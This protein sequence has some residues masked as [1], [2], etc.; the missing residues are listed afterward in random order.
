[1]TVKVVV[2][3]R[4]LRPTAWIAALI[5]AVTMVSGC[6]RAGGQAH[7]FSGFDT[8]APPPSY[9]IPAGIMAGP[10]E[11]MWYVLRD[12]A[13][14]AVGEIDNSGQTVVHDLP[15]SVAQIYDATVGPDG[16]VWFTMMVGGTLGR[17]MDTYPNL[18]GGS[19][20]VGRMDS[21]GQVRVF[22]MPRSTQV[23]AVIAN[24]AGALWI[25][26]TAAG[27]VT[28]LLWRLRT[29]GSF[30]TYTPPGQIGTLF[31]D[32]ERR[33]W[34]AA[35]LTG[36]NDV[37]ESG[38]GWIDTDGQAHAVALP[39]EQ[40]GWTRAG[41]IGPDG[42]PWFSIGQKLVRLRPDGT[43]EAIQSM[44]CA[45]MT[46][47]GSDLWCAS[48]TT[49]DQITSTGSVTTHA[50]PV[51]SGFV[52]LGSS[53]TAGTDGVAAAADGSIWYTD[54]TNSVIWHYR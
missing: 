35:E 50:L 37:A 6:A 36:P 53:M 54:A 25:T 2:T 28:Q 20:A 3:R 1:M 48:P 8:F 40:Q 9:V 4:R 26:G 43:F 39:Q 24:F 41:A 47:S 33:L 13:T 14:S 32:G 38:I 30:T 51:G 7:T 42:D 15:Q 29:D 12:G 23:P 46:G 34:Y 31:S 49:L 18:N 44:S 21:T 17:T 11:H 19:G 45:P 16:A 22:P 5:V 10:N 27:S 52:T